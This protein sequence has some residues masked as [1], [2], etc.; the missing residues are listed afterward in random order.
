[1]INEDIFKENMLN[2]K[3]NKPLNV[4]L[5]KLREYAKNKFDEEYGGIIFVRDFKKVC[6][7]CGEDFIAH[8]S[9]K[10]YC[11]K[12]KSKHGLFVPQNRVCKQCGKD[13]IT[14][15]HAK[16]YCNTCS[17]KGKNSCIEC[18]KSI[19]VLAKRCNT[20]HNHILSIFGNSVYHLNSKMKNSKQL[21]VERIKKEIE[22]DIKN[23][24]EDTKNKI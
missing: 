16:L 8:S 7:K 15:H 19:G 4:P 9:G 21:S 24:I 12:C 5:M 14:R 17:I 22:M 1:M 13:F 6:K 3:D 10:Q 18:G 2:I 23:F 20:C 11:T